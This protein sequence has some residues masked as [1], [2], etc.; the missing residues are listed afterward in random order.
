MVILL[1]A[2][3]YILYPGFEKAASAYQ[4]LWIPFT[5]GVAIGYVFLYLLPKLSDYTDSIRVEG[6]QGIREILD[7]RVY[8]YGLLGFVFYYFVDQYKAQKNRKQIGPKILLGSGFFIY[9]LLTGYILANW[10][11]PGLI[12]VFLAGSILTLH[13]LGVNHQVRKWHRRVFDDYFR[14]LFAIALI[15][16]WGA[17]IFLDIPREM[18]IVVTGMLAG[19]I[20]TNIMNEEIPNRDPYKIVPFIAG[21]VLI[22]IVAVFTRSLPRFVV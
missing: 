7:Y 6:V 22:T 14:W 12:P 5:G 11:R 1:M 17:G 3:V 10:S 13:L 2:A 20:I 16:G 4:H 9:S 15:I 21:V 18:E 8:L 19:G